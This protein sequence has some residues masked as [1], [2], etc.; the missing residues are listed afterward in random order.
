MSNHIELWKPWSEIPFYKL[1]ET[2]K[3]MQGYLIAELRTNF[4]HLCPKQV[5]ISNNLMIK[6]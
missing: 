3:T 1:A 4:L 5:K 2:S 6:S